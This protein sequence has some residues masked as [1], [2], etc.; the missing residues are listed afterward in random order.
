MTTI[1]T[2]NGKPAADNSATPAQRGFADLP[3]VYCGESGCLTIDLCDLTGDEALTCTQCETNY[4]LAD[5]RAKIAA[6]LPVIAWI[7]QAPRLPE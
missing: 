5:V 6:W 3:C 7:D 2:T 1:A 4:S